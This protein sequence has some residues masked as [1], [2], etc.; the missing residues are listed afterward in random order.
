MGVRFAHAQAIARSAVTFTGYKGGPDNR[1]G[2]ADLQTYLTAGSRVYEL[3]KGLDAVA[4]IPGRL[5][6][7]RN[8]GGHYRGG[9]TAYKS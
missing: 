3:K 4:A 7:S 1:R 5:H 8:G 6:F 2:L 9:R